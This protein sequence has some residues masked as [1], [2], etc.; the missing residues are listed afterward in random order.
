MIDKEAILDELTSDELS[1]S[2]KCAKVQMLSELFYQDGLIKNDVVEK[3]TL[4][5]KSLYLL[6]YLEQNS[7][8]YS[9]DREQKMSDITK[10]LMEYS[11]TN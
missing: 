4:L 7:K 1:D 11:A 2:D 8:T 9:W 5:E 10:F 3:L 6:R